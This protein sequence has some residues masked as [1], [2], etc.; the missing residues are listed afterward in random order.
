MSAPFENAYKFFCDDYAGT[1]F[2]L[3]TNKVILQNRF[4]RISEFIYQKITSKE[5]SHCSFLPQ[6]RAYAAKHRHHLRRTV[7]L[8]PVSEFFVYEMVYRHRAR[9]RTDIFPKRRCFGFRFVNGA[10]VS[11][12]QGYIDF[13]GAIQE[14]CAVFRYSA[15]FDV[16]SYFNS[17]Y[18][19]DLTG[20]FAD[21]SNH[22]DDTAIFGK[23]LR[24][25][26]AGRSIDCLT[27]GLMP[28]KI[29]GAQFLKFVDNHPRLECES[30][31]RFMDDFVL[32]SNDINV[33]YRD[34]IYI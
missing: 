5:D 8:D 24:Q 33:L 1:L 9:F 2:P 32:F 16:S 12:A 7:K 21:I 18:H 11:P 22:D 31:L 27:H 34:F 17:I 10:P 3:E 28:T 19:H 26:N 30:Y 4:Q 25:I 23:F 15:R 6:E 14:E 29:I 20:W 13:K